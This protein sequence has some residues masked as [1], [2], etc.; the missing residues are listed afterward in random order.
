MRGEFDFSNWSEQVSVRVGPFTVTPY[1]VNHPIAEAYALRVEATEPG[2]DGKAKV[3]V[4]AYSGDTD[5]C[6]GLLE[7]AR[8]ANFFLCEAA[9]EEGR[10]DAIRNVH[11]TGKRAAEAAVQANAER[12]LLTHVPVWTDSNTVLADAK[13]EFLGDVAVAVAGVHYTI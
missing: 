13:P 9:F 3:S 7:A 2:D 12:L 1:G 6:Q 8:D 4:L 10:D 5:S 11:L